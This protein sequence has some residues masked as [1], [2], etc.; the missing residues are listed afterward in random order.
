MIVYLAGPIDFNSGSAVNEH[1]YQLTQ[2]FKRWP[3]VW[4]YDP[5]KAWSGAE[6]PKPDEFVHWANISVLEQADLLVAVLMRN[7]LTVGTILEMQHAHDKD[8][9]IMVVGDVSDASISLAAL[10]ALIMDNTAEMNDAFIEAVIFN[11][12]RRPVI[13]RTNC[14]CL[15]LHAAEHDCDCADKSVR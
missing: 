2:Y 6:N 7:T 1:R 11:S 5:S 10:D 8:I 14:E 12:E 4:V 13:E 9:P 3:D 15:A